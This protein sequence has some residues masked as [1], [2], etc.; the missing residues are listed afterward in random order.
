M[1]NKYY[2]YILLCKDKSLYCGI[3]KDI[4][5]REK[6]HN[7]GKGSAYVRSRGGGKIVYSKLFY[8]ISSALKREA[9]VKT[10]TRKEKLKLVK[11]NEALIRVDKRSR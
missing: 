4:V 8:S 1:K 2:F 10:W 9:E 5:K 7:A 11:K 3:A 6:L